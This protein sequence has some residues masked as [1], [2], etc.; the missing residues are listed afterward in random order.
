MNISLG[1]NIPYNQEL[2]KTDDITNKINKKDPTEN[3]LM[4]ACRGFEAYMLEQ[5][6]KEMRKTVESSDESGDYMQ[7]FG[8]MLYEEHAKNATEN[9]G[10]GIAK[11]L[12]ESMKRDYNL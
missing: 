6:F 9:E 4:E 3:E 10:I 1:T 12:F 11:M 2:A 8:D 5:V 7:Y